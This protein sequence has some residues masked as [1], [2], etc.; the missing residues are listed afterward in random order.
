MKLL[1]MAVSLLLE[2]SRTSSLGKFCWKNS[3]H[4]PETANLPLSKVMERPEKFL[5]LR[6]LMKSPGGNVHR[7]LNERVW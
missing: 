3:W 2:R 4:Y 5:H 6:N 7:S 1:G